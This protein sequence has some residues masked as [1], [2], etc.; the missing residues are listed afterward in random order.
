[1]AAWEIHFDPASVPSCFRP[2]TELGHACQIN[3]DRRV[4]A[5]A[6]AGA[7]A[8]TRT[9]DFYFGTIGEYYFGTDRRHNCPDFG[10]GPAGATSTP[11][12]AEAWA[13]RSRARRRN[14][15]R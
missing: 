6:P 12:T 4:A 14:P 11:P 1:M 9:G 5:T 2:E 15:D 3:T 13:F 10:S 8:A 7:V